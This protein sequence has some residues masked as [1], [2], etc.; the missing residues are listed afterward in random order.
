[1]SAAWQDQECDQ[2]GVDQAAGVYNYPSTTWLC[3]S[4][5]KLAAPLMMMYLQLHCGVMFQQLSKAAGPMLTGHQLNPSMPLL[6]PSCTPSESLHFTCRSA[7]TVDLTPQRHYL[8]M[9]TSGH[10][11]Q[12]LEGPEA[13]SAAASEAALYGH[14]C[15][16]HMPDPSQTRPGQLPDDDSHFAPA[17]T[18]GQLPTMLHAIQRVP[19]HPFSLHL[20]THLDVMSWVTVQSDKPAVDDPRMF[21][22]LPMHLKINTDGTNI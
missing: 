14:A 20:S 6:Y 10:R 13:A 18:A 19:V 9:A 16:V 12:D 22:L 21:S 11:T 15:A 8:Q 5:A 3:S 17:T 2:Y 4:L 1:M 7:M